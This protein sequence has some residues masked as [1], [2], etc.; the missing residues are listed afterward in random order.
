MLGKIQTGMGYEYQVRWNEH[1]AAQMRVEG[2]A[3][4]AGRVR[5]TS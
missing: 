5:G 2:R 4:A 1:V 3:A